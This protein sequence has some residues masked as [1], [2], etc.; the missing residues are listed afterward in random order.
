MSIGD[1]IA[2]LEAEVQ[3]LMAASEQQKIVNEALASELRAIRK[4]IGLQSASDRWADLKS[5]G[6]SPIPDDRARERRRDIVEKEG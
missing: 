2:G 5:K 1:R 3:A 6:G 4:A